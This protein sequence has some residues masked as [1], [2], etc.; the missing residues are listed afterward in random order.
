VVYAFQCT[1]AKEERGLVVDVWKNIVNAGKAIT[2]NATKEIYQVQA[3]TKDA[4]EKAIAKAAADFET[5]RAKLAESIKAGIDKARNVTEDI[6]AKIEEGAEGLR[7][8]IEA[9]IQAT[10][11][12]VDEAVEQAKQRGANV[13]KCVSDY[14]GNVS[15]IAN[16]TSK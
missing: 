14:N 6:R 4:V 2:A 12:S 10:K 16:E 11:E 15:A 9:A 8:G 13:A 5:F 1:L 7:S 3:S